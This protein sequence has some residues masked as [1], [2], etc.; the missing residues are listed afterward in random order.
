MVWEPLGRHKRLV[1]KDFREHSIDCRISVTK[2][3]QMNMRGCMI[4]REG[5]FEAKRCQQPFAASGRNKS[6]SQ[7]V[8][9]ALDLPVDISEERGAAQQHGRFGHDL[10]HDKRTGVRGKPAGFQVG[11]PP[12]RGIG[13]RRMPERR[14]HSASGNVQGLLHTPDENATARQF[15]SLV[16]HNGHGRRCNVRG[17]DYSE[18]C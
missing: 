16:P 17:T 7:F 14:I 15:T 13:L 18:T 8:N 6:L 2:G 1:L 12:V 5:G 3:S 9:G 4:K 11:S 10:P